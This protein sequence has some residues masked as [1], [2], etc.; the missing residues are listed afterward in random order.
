MNVSSTVTTSLWAA[1]K[2]FALVGLLLCLLPGRWGL[3]MTVAS[4]SVYIAM[5]DA[6][7]VSLFCLATL[8]GIIAWILQTK[9]LLNVAL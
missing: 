6:L 7:P 3:S 8:V 2:G 9:R 4:R 5:R 1:S